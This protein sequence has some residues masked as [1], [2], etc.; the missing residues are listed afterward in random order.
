VAS[1]QSAEATKSAILQMGERIQG[2]ILS[3]HDPALYDKMT[4]S[5]ITP[6][7]R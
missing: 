3:F 5:G 6:Q 4:K 7:V 1:A 2:D